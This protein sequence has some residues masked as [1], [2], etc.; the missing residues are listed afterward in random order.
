M[1]FIMSAM[2]LTAVF[3]GGLGVSSAFAQSGY[4]HHN[5]CLNAGP[6]RECAYQTMEQCEA[7]KR[8]GGDFCEP[9]SAPMD[10]P[11]T[12]PRSQ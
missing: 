6:S 9:N 4:V 7:A 10:H 2:L 8:G 3:A 1:R 12:H 5:F 11:A